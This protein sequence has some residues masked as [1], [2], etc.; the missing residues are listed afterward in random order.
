[1]SQIERKLDKSAWGYGEWHDEPDLLNYTTDE[2]FDAAIVRVSHSGALCGYVGVSDS[3]PLYGKDYGHE[4]KPT[5]EQMSRKV[6]IDN[7]SVISLFCA[8]L[9]E[10][11]PANGARLDILIDVHGGMTYADK[12]RAN[13]GEN[14]KRWYFGFDCAHSGDLC[15]A[16]DRYFTDGTYRDIEYVKAN[17]ARLSKQLAGFGSDK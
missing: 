15:P 4:V 2:G 1:V 14:P 12:G 6:D 8:A 10:S 9:S 16:M 7:V 5:E 17:V 13:L 11:D 3:H